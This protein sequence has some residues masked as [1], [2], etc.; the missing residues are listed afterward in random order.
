MAR[1][2]QFSLLVLLACG[3][4]APAQTV[5]PPQS[6]PAQS[7]N[8]AHIALG[9]SVVPLDGPWKFQ[10]G[11]SPVDP[12]TRTPLWAQPG[13]DDSH[14]EIVDVTPKAGATDPISGVSG[15]VPGWTVKGHPGYWGYAW[16]RIQVRISTRPDVRLALAGPSDVDDVYQV[17]NNGNLIGAF[18]DFSKSTPTTFTARPAMFA[19]PPEEGGRD[20][21]R[22]LA[23]RVWME[24]GTLQQSDETGGF[25]SAPLLGELGA[26][27]EQ[28]ELQWAELY[29]A[30]AGSLIVGLLFALLGVV[31][32]SLVLFDRTDHVYLWIG[33]LLLTE[34]AFYLMAPIRSWT[35]WIPYRLTAP[36]RVALLAPLIAAGWVMVWRAWFR[37]RSPSWVPWVVAVQLA[38]LT[39]LNALL[40]DL[41]TIFSGPVTHAIHLVSL[42]LRMSIAAL[43]LAAVFQ[44]IREQGLE[45]WIALPAALL[46]VIAEFYQELSFEHIVEVWFPFG[47]QLTTRQL[48]DLVLV[49]VLSVLLLRRLVLSVRLQRRMAL[50]VKQAQEVQQVILPEACLKLPGFV[51]ESEYRPALEVGGDFF[52]IIPHKTDGSLLIV[53]GDVTGKGLKAGML[54]ALLV[55]AVR[56]TADW[57]DDPVVVLR[58]LNQRLLG[59]S[60]AQ[61]TSL[62]LR[63][64]KDGA[65]KLTNA[66]HMPPYLNGEPVEMEGSLP[67]GVIEGAE[68]SVMH[69]QL[70]EDDKLVLLS[71]GIAEATDS[72]G[73]LFGFERVLELLRSPTN[74][75]EIARAAQSF[76]QEDDISV[77]SVTRMAVPEQAIA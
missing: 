47:V 11:D 49:A 7:D 55:G 37:L 75:A 71:D 76:G 62:A 61:A 19:L 60:D 12:A 69:F 4:L 26:V 64:A 40:L 3:V 72:E 74:A 8:A 58:A 48:A 17:F 25:H 5:R 24:P 65:V 52:Q 42:V 33:A 54:V 10:V 53:A 6:L 13:F 35:M 9:Q 68:F 28:Q 39:I 27:A 41:F 56:S 43:L 50:D 36:F 29:R 77:I 51:V 18:G 30:Y 20:S 73:Q 70:K 46:A 38:L 15:Y 23:F 63:I 66:G 45:G 67:L 44:G 1:R 57:S 31:A 34:A 2:L 59:R 22:L 21:N 14:W 16:Y 32:I